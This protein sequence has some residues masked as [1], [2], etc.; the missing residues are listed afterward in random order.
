VRN[1]IGV[2]RLLAL[3]PLLCLAGGSVFAEAGAGE[4]YV[5]IG[6]DA[7]M[8]VLVLFNFKVATVRVAAS[9][10]ALKT[11]AALPCKKEVDDDGGITIRSPKIPLPSPAAGEGHPTTTIELTLQGKP[12]DVSL[13][14]ASATTEIVDKDGAKWCYEYDLEGEMANSAKAAVLNRIL[15]SEPVSLRVESK[16]DPGS[17]KGKKVGIGIELVTTGK[18]SIHSVKKDGSEVTAHV[19]VTDPAGTVISNVDRPLTDLGFG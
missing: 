1:A 2:T 12:G 4:Y 9:E 18:L 14:S 7:A 17:S 13:D 15:T 19:Q 3:L 10:D 8:A 6:P 11:A 5:K 16:F